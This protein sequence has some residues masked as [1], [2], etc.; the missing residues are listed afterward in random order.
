MS[1][2]SRLW[3]KIQNNGRRR[4]QQGTMRMHMRRTWGTMGTREK[5]MMMNRSQKLPANL[6]FYGIDRHHQH[7]WLIQACFWASMFHTPVT[8][9]M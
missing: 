5:R 7:W 9:L 3:M 4:P 1:R 8:P 2:R 6:C